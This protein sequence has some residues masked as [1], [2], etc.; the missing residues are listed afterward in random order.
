M[1]PAIWTRRPNRGRARHQRS[2]TTG[3]GFMA[4]GHGSKMVEPQGLSGKAARARPDTAACGCPNRSSRLA[5]AAARVAATNCRICGSDNPSAAR[6]IAKSWRRSSADGR[7]NSSMIA[8]RRRSA[9]SSA[10]ARFVQ[11]IDHDAAAIPAQIIDALNQRVHRHLVL[12]V[13]V[14]LRRAAAEAIAF[15]DDQDRAAAACRRTA[16][17]F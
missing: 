5:V 4:G 16:T 12:M 13:A 9:G 1:L 6:S 7:L 10:G 15:V 8:A 17:T 3:D 11:R 14:I 2:S